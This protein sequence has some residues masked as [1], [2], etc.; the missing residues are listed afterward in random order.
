MPSAGLSNRLALIEFRVPRKSVAVILWITEAQRAVELILRLPS[1]KQP[2]GLEP[3]EVR[4]IAEGADPKHLQE[5]PRRHI[6]ERRAGLGSAD[7]ASIRPQR[8]REAMMS[9]LISRPASF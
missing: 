2:F 9:R 3:L 7:G 4:Q 5:F 6:G 8:L 1:L